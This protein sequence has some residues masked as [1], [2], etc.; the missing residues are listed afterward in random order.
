M[1]FNGISEMDIKNIK[2]TQGGSNFYGGKKNNEEILDFV[3]LKCYNATNKTKEVYCYDA[4]AF[5]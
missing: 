4:N 2:S 5:P 3:T 1:I